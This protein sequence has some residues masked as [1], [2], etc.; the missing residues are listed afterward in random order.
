MQQLLSCVRLD[1]QLICTKT[2]N[3]GAEGK[4]VGLEE[5]GTKTCDVMRVRESAFLVHI[6][7]DKTML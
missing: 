3:G 5:R 7:G 6:L 2:M 4:V 1:F